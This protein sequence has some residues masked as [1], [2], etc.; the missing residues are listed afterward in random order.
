[1]EQ[2]D[3]HWVSLSHRV[4]RGL[5]HE[6]IFYGQNHEMMSH[7]GISTTGTSKDTRSL[8]STAFRNPKTRN[9][10]KRL[11]AIST[12]RLSGLQRTRDLTT[13]SL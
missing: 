13:L 12:F 6:L 2:I 1:M 10:K 3:D 8:S 4:A 11:G 5:A 9:A 7:F